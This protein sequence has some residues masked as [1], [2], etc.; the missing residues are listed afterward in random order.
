ML[1]FSDF[2]FYNRFV[3]ENEIKEIYN[4]RPF[5]SVAY[6][7]DAGYIDAP[8]AAGTPVTVTATVNNTSDKAENIILLFARLNGGVLKE[9]KTVP[10]EA[11]ENNA[12]IIK[13][14]I[15]IR[16]SRGTSFCVFTWDDMGALRPW[17]KK[18][19]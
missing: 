5:V 8:L 12:Q 15:L 3:Y 11:T 6:K 1:N 9:V 10:L 2:V 7:T 17:Q 19:C 14:T 18:D 4:S 16:W 13:H